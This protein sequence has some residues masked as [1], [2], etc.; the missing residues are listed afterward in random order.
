MKTRLFTDQGV[1]HSESADTLAEVLVGVGLLG[2][3]FASLFSGMSRCTGLTQIAREDLRATQILLERIEGIRLF[4]WNQLVYSN[5]LCPAT[6]TSSYC[7]I[8]N[9]SGSTGFTY[10]GTMVI[11]NISDELASSY[12]NQIRAIIVTLNWTNAG[13]SHT[14]K[15]TTYQAKYGAQNYA[16]NN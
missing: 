12:S 9:D 1:C 2:L 16:F 10:Y 4:N 5:N 13:V 8:A 6:F 3:F 7:P 11:T 14:R 15:M